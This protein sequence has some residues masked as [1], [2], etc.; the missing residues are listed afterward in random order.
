M[1]RSE[2]APETPS[3][4]AEASS[5]VATA[6]GRQA[7]IDLALAQWARLFGPDALAPRAVRLQDW[8]DEAPTATLH[9]ERVPR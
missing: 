1:T 3:A 6:H 9:A 7:L 2:P 8:A 4:V 5:P